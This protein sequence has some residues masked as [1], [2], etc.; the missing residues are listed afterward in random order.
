MALLDDI[1]TRLDAESVTGGATGW[2]AFTSFLPTDPDKAVA[3]FETGGDT[4]EMAM[5]GTNY[6]KPTFQVRIRGE[7]FE[8]ETARQKA[9]DAINALHRYSVNNQTFFAIQSGPLSIGNDEND[10]PNL[11][12]NFRVTDVGGF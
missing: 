2:S 5:G 9:Q 7:S 4:P 10:R 1:K 11:T 12:V 3:V 6:P 8:Y